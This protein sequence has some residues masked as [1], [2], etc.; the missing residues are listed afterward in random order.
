MSTTPETAGRSRFPRFRWRRVWSDSIRPIGTVAL[1]VFGFR[2]A[3]ADW[4]HVPTGSMQPTILVGDRVFVNRL[5]YDLKVPFTTWHLAEWADPERGDVVIFRSPVD[6]QRLVKR[7]VGIPGDV[8]A[9]VDNR[10]TLNGQPVA[11]EP[12]EDAGAYAMSLPE[13]E[14]TGAVFAAERLPEA[15]QDAHPVMGSVGRR[16]LRDF[17]PVTVP[18]DH[19]FM[20]GDNRDNSL[21]SRYFGSVQRDTI[22]GRAV[23]VVG[24]LDPDRHYRPRWERTLLPLP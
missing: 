12:A 18:K 20:M 14:R 7:V 8:V 15:R 6:G 3:V 11:Y 17:G 23:R 10:L 1:A 19:Y 22:L 5:A 16:A 21:D 2:S 13:P 9:M 4:N 24:S